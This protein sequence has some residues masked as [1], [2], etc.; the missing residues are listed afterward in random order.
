MGI[1]K[2]I[3]TPKQAKSTFKKLLKEEVDD[4]RAKDEL[5]RRRQQRGGN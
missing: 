4:K 5:A 1:R 3:G 2:L